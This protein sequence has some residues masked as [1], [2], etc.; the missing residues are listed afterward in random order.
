MPTFS[1][2]RTCLASL[3]VPRYVTAAELTHFRLKGLSAFALRWF[4]RDLNPLPTVYHTDALPIEL[5]NRLAADGRQDTF[6]CL[7]SYKMRTARNMLSFAS[8]SHC[9]YQ[10]DAALAC[11]ARTYHPLS[12]NCQNFLFC[13]SP[14]LAGP[15]LNGCPWM[16]LS[17]LRS[18]DRESAF[19][20]T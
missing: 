16:V 17:R 10:L 15:T 4:L 19:R 9:C 2:K 14:A 18:Y 1:T 8:Y 7:W 3:S 12:P 13:I 6:R 5:K 20:R 11:W